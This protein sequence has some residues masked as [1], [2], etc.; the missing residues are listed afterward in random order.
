MSGYFSSLKESG[1]SL[2]NTRGA[3]PA[4]VWQAREFGDTNGRASD[5]FL[6]SQNVTMRNEA[7]Q[8][9]FDSADPFAAG[10][11]GI[12]REIS[13]GAV[14]ADESMRPQKNRNQSPSDSI[15]TGELGSQ[16]RYRDSLPAHENITSSQ[17][18]F[19]PENRTSTHKVSKEFIVQENIQQENIQ[20]E[21]LAPK[22][23]IEKNPPQNDTGKNLPGLKTEFSEFSAAN[24]GKSKKYGQSKNLFHDDVQ[25]NF[26]AQKE[27]FF[28]TESPGKVPHILIQ[29]N[30]QS[31]K[32][33]SLI[34]MDYF[35]ENRAL[36]VESKSQKQSEGVTL[37]IG[38]VELVIEGAPQLK[39]APAARPANV[40]RKAP[41]G[42][43]RLRRRFVTM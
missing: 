11:Y 3:S 16:E 22:T 4:T 23:D 30:E 10:K 7:A 5:P 20:F 37:S 13:F 8:P 14:P 24:S 31:G 2:Q 32:N 12:E 41:Q 15:F 35:Y 42:N 9:F 38:E 18:T 6:E 19:V 25:I 33:E 40:P 29:N 17:K 26:T 43:T 1:L 28:E 36:R 27:G 34:V 39:S 21:K